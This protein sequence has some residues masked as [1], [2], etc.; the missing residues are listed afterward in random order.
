M[1]NSSGEE[2]LA[3]Q[4]AL[5]E[6]VST[7]DPNY[8]Y[9][10]FFIGLEGSFGNRHLTPRTLTSRFLNNIVCLEGIATQCKFFYSFNIFFY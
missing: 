6:Y 1:L 2:H 5:K 9:D 8:E 10:E 7:V 3:F 4:N